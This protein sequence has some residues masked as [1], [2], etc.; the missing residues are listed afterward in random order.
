MSLL[1][2]DYHERAGVRE[3]YETYK[4][5]PIYKNEMQLE[6]NFNLHCYDSR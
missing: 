1:E 4:N 3:R 2:Q 6:F 5:A